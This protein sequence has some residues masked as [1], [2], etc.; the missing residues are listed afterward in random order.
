[1]QSPASASLRA[2]NKLYEDATECDSRAD[3]ICDYVQNATGNELKR[4]PQGKNASSKRSSGGHTRNKNGQSEVEAILNSGCDN[5]YDR[6]HY[7]NIERG[8]EHLQH[9][10]HSSLA[11]SKGRLRKHKNDNENVRKIADP[12]ADSTAF[13]T[14]TTKQRKA[15]LQGCGNN[16]GDGD[17]DYVICDREACDDALPEAAE[18]L[19][20]AEHL[21]THMTISQ[22]TGNAS[23]PPLCAVSD[24]KDRCMVRVDMTPNTET[25]V[26]VTTPHRTPFYA[27]NGL[28]GGL[29]IGPGDG[30]ER[31]LSPSEGLYHECEH[32]SGYLDVHEMLDRSYDHDLEGLYLSSQYD[33]C[34]TEID[35]SMRHLDYDYRM[36]IPAFTQTKGVSQSISSSSLSSALSS[37]SSLLSPHVSKIVR[38]RSE[39]SVTDR[40]LSSEGGE[41]APGGCHNAT[42]DFKQPPPSSSSSS[43]SSS[44]ATAAPSIHVNAIADDT[45]MKV[46]RRG[47]KKSK[48]RALALALAMKEAAGSAEFCNHMGI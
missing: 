6:R 40:N 36:H 23:S 17:G 9:T 14:K 20:E 43:S 41:N 11:D 48:K 30:D 19:P 28:A 31:P 21:P 18:A 46:R 12:N 10:E 29:D 25:E 32:L 42:L 38:S 5:D 26:H 45:T 4:L 27:M 39:S 13:E 34:V 3:G 22:N 35:A 44:S 16:D 8:V 2:K 24:S 1:M 37:S 15:E 33:E 47:L 7:K